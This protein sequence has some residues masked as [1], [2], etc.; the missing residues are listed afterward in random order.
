MSTKS[1]GLWTSTFPVDVPSSTASE[2]APSSSTLNPEKE[3]RRYF[4]IVDILTGSLVCV[5]LVLIILCAYLLYKKVRSL[6]SQNNI[7]TGNEMIVFNRAY[8][9]DTV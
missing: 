7:Y 9:E 4:V 1:N 5:T 2:H 6:R 8:D 3:D